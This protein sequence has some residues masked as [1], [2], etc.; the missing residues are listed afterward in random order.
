MTNTSE[1]CT[2]F[3]LEAF[4]QQL[5]LQAA[6]VM[7]TRTV[8]FSRPRDGQKIMNSLLLILELLLQK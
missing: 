6:N 8:Q 4:F 2:A 1:P 7:Y 5:T 3:D